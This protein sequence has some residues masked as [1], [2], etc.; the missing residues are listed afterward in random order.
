[1]VTASC[2]TALFSPP[3]EIGRTALGR[4]FPSFFFFSPFL[5]ADTKSDASY[6]PCPGKRSAYGLLGAAA[7]SPFSPLSPPSPSSVHTPAAHLFFPMEVI[8]WLSRRRREVPP[9]SFFP[10]TRANCTRDLFPLSSLSLFLSRRSSGVDLGGL[11]GHAGQ[12][13]TFRYPLLADPTGQVTPSFFFSCWSTRSTGNVASLFP[14]SLFLTQHTAV[15]C[16]LNRDP[17]QYFLSLFLSFSLT[18]AGP[19]TGSAP[20][21]LPPFLAVRRRKK[22]EQSLQLSFLSLLRRG[23]SKTKRPLFSPLSILFTFVSTRGE[24]LR[25]SAGTA[26]GRGCGPSIDFQKAF[27]LS[28]LP[29]PPRPGGCRP[30]FFLRCDCS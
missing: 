1:M 15:R 12:G 30:F 18:P 21:S 7:A 5:K 26:D 3:S 20:F 9:L 27:L 22:H 10:A 24:F 8:R 17:P 29:F 11:G 6:D 23:R 19:R 13:E 25:V 28:F 16:F 14:L 4:F 2:S